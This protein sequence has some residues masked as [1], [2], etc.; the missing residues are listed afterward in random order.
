M[1]CSTAELAAVL[2][3][4]ATILLSWRVLY[5]NSGG[6]EGTGVVVDHGVFRRLEEA[7]DGDPYGIQWQSWRRPVPVRPTAMELL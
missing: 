7:V 3:V 2:T 4:L 6:F 5:P 1:A